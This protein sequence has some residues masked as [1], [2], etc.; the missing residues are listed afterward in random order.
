[1]DMITLFIA[2]ETTGA[3]QWR[4]PDNDPAQ[5]HVV[6]VVAIARTDNGTGID[7]FCTLIRPE[8]DWHFEDGAVN[9]HGITAA[10]AADRGQPAEAVRDRLGRLLLMANIVVGFGLDFQLRTLRR[11]F[12]DAP[13]PIPAGQFCCMKVARDVVKK[14]RMQP[15][16]GYAIPTFAETYRHIA[17][18]ELPT[19]DDPIDAGL[20][21]VSAVR[22]IY[23][24]LMRGKS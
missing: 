16:G 15:G 10:V 18:A 6:R 14:P 24:G 21:K 20:L 8:A 9:A 4:L 5:P 23:D 7:E 11:L 17:G 22:T 1:M 12:D 19:S 13:A 3:W 2:C